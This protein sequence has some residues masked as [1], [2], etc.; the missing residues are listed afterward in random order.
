MTII[1]IVYHDEYYDFFFS[2]DLKF[3][4]CSS[5]INSRPFLEIDERPSLSLALSASLAMIAWELKHTLIEFRHLSCCRFWCIFHR[6]MRRL[7]RFIWFDGDRNKSIFNKIIMIEIN[8]NRRIK[9][10]IEKNLRCTFNEFMMTIIIIL[11]IYQWINI[12]III[13]TCWNMKML[14]KCI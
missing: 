12:K 8:L 2:N 14:N 11:I 1:I 4:L 9:W 6:L 13:E 10:N 5:P 7:Y 3:L